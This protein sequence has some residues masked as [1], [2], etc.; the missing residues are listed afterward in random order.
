MTVNK[1]PSELWNPVFPSAMLITFLNNHWFKQSGICPL[2]SGKLSDIGIMIF[3]PAAICLSIV[4]LKFTVNLLRR[5]DVPQYFLSRWLVLFSI[6]FSGFLMVL[7]KLSAEA[8]VVYYNS[9]N[10]LNKLLFER[11]IAYPVRDITDLFSV[12]FLY[13]PYRI[14][15]K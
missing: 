10:T 12:L 14:L 2:L 15:S 3:L 6:A 5:K 11:T 1:M 9:L 7:L 8:G 13:I 4:Y